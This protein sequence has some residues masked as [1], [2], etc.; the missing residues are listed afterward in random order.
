M[1]S[2]NRTLV[3][4][5]PITQDGVNAIVKPYSDAIL[6]NGAPN[7]PCFVLHPKHLGCTVNSFVVLKKVF[8]QILP[9]YMALNFV[10][11]FVMS[12][13]FVFFLYLLF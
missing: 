11:M 12:I 2:L 13:R 5:L 7:V 3:R 4:G 6:S 1:L 9:V 10:P 8:L